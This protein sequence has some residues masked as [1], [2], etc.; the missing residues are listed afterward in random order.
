MMTHLGMAVHLAVGGRDDAGHDVLGG[1]LA[2]GAH[3][4]ARLL[5]LLQVV[6]Q[7]PRVT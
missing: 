3:H 4:L 2:A 7:Q 6:Q 5:Q 1:D